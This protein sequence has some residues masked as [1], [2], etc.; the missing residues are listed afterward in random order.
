MLQIFGRLKN[1]ET[2]K[3]L[4]WYKERRIAHQFI[5]LKE[6]SF[7]HGELRDIG[8]F[9]A[10][11]ELIDENSPEY[12]KMGLAYLEF[13]PL[14]LL[15]EKPILLRGPLVRTKNAVTIG[16]KPEIWKLWFNLG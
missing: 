3:T 15:L 16:Y 2:Q 13:D 9:I 1:H 6:R 14:G 10:L 8:R 12:K 4:R 5:D 11:K 7:S